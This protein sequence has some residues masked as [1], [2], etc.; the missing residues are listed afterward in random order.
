MRGPEPWQVRA[1]GWAGCLGALLLAW[2]YGVPFLL[3]VGFI[4]RTST[5][6]L[7]TH[8]QARAF[9][10][11]TDTILVTAL[12]LNL[13]LPAAGLLLA[14]LLR[15][16]PW[17]RQFAWTLGGTALIYVAV[18]IAPAAATAPL[19]GRT[20]AD[21]EPAPAVTRCIPISGGRGCPGG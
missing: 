12:A 5:P 10:A 18:S 11:T 4:R 6:H 15:S 9:G 14:L 21:Q 20:P 1:H 16:R 7:A 17:I 3:I 19:I 13:A 8:A 2:L